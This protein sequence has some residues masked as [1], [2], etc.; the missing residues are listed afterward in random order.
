MGWGGKGKAEGEGK[1][2]EVAFSPQTSIPGTATGNDMPIYSLTLALFMIDGRQKLNN[3][4][5]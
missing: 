2:G 3:A 4:P 1:G 5:L